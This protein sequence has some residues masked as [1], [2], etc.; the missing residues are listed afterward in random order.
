[1]CLLYFAPPPVEEPSFV[2]VLYLYELHTMGNQPDLV[3]ILISVTVSFCHLYELH[4][5]GNQPDLVSIL[6]SVTV[7]FCHFRYPDIYNRIN[8]TYKF[9]TNFPKSHDAGS[10]ILYH[11][12]NLIFKSSV[13]LLMFLF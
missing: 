1:M 13:C 12:R 8:R 10:H 5:M 6:I 4:T 2:V 11:F 7:S 3:S 9:Y